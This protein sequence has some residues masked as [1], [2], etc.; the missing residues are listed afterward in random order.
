MMG[1]RLTQRRALVTGASSGIGA[2]IAKCLA[3]EG[4]ALVLVA[5]RQE[6]L[7]ALATELRERHGVE[8]AVEA[9]DLTAPG[10]GTA[11]CERLEAEGP[12]DVLVNNAGFGAWDDFTAIPWET[13]ARMLQ[14]NMVALTE[15]TWC[16]ARKMQER[17]RGNLL[18]I[19]STAAYSPCPNFAV[20]AAT[21]AYVRNFSEALDYE[22][23]KSGVRSLVVC[24]GGTRTEFSDVSAQKLKKSADY[25]M[26]DASA[27]AKIAVGRML[28][29]R[30]TVVAGFLNALSVWLL[31]FLP[32]AW[33]PGATA[34]AMAGAVE[35]AE[36][37]AS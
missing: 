21:K 9:L 28:R 31:R 25:A 13:H 18:H 37:A 2:E 29:G 10:A 23:K 16:F 32:R 5:R 36:P 14:L 27:V 6:R 4:A 1:G 3:A 11:L 15:L 12:V 24:P 30:R 20:Y 26:M 17:G 7:E 8:V 22:L 33:L 34:M 35:K 19:A